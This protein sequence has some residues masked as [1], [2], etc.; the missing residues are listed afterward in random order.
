[1]TISQMINA[2]KVRNI[3]VAKAENIEAI[4]DAFFQ[5]LAMSFWIFIFHNNE[6]IY[7]P[8][9][10]NINMNNVEIVH[11]YGALRTN[12]NKPKM[13]TIYNQYEQ[14]EKFISFILNYVTI[15]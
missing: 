2:T 11:T 13:Q 5:P 1:M 14:K 8:A 15:Y 6:N 7:S 9:D 3:T 10:V 4:R 12:N